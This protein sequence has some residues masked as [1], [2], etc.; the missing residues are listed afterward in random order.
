MSNHTQVFVGPRSLELHATLACL[1]RALSTLRYLGLQDYNN[2]VPA[3]A[4]ADK[5][6]FLCML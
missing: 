1:N 4:P 6:C 3:Q 2:N 5:A